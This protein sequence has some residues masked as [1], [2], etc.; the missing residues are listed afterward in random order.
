M[1]SRGALFEIL[2][3]AILSLSAGLVSAKAKED[4]VFASALPMESE[5]FKAAQVLLGIISERI[6]ENI[7]L[8]FIPGKRSAVLLKSNEIHAELARVGEY[9]NKVPFALK[10][11]EPII[12]AS[13]YAYSI[14]HD[15]RVAGWGSLKPYRSVSLRGTWIVEVFMAEHNVTYVDSML[16][17]FQ[18]LKSGRSDIWVTSNLRAEPFFDSVNVDKSDI[19]RLEPAIHTSREFTYFAKEYPD[20]AKRYEQAL[21][22]MKKDGSYQKIL[23]QLNM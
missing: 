17:A 12:E 13:H 18:F 10:V 11:A 20:L 14:K 21:I 16:S 19:K 1:K 8:I 2:I 15:F 3:V 22:S 5:L 23:S 9:Q 7:K 4:I 6:G